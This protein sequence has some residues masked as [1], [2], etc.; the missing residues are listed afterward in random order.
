MTIADPAATAGD[1][2]LPTPAPDAGVDPARMTTAAVQRKVLLV[3]RVPATLLGFIRQSSG[4]HQLCL[5]GVSVAVF[6][7]SAAPLEIQRRLVND[8][9]KGNAYRPILVL[10]VAYAGVAL[11]EGVM[12]LVMNMYRAWIS[13]HSVRS[14]RR[15]IHAALDGRSTEHQSEDSRGIGVSMILAE[16][17]PIGGY[18]GSSISEPI[19]QAGILA[20]VL[21]YMVFL[22]PV[23]AVVALV[24]LSPQIVLVPLVQRAINR[25]VQ[26][27]IRTLRKVSIAVTGDAENDAPRR[28]RRRIDRVLQL[29]LWVFRLKFSMN[30][31]MNLL[32]HLGTAGILALGGWYVVQGET[33]VGT[34]VAFAAGLAKITDPWRDLIAWYR[35][36]NVARAKYALLASGVHDLLGETPDPSGQKISRPR[37]PNQAE[38]VS[39][40]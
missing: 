26:Q 29:N 1:P 5:L 21:G 13:E 31:V 9:L 30:F 22:H 7:L 27:K 11:G 4:W 3:Q 36:M 15:S 17:E 14:L 18:V 37:E 2:E 35:E 33:E 16:A 34:V 8:A 28:Q 12:K 19:L 20:S 10:A 23:M 40:P 39:P 32:T 25:R 24:V 6:L 38:G